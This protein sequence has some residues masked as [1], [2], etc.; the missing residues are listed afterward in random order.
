VIELVTL[1][2]RADRVWLVGLVR[3]IDRPELAPDL[4]SDT[5]ASQQLV[6]VFEVNLDA[7][8]SFVVVKD[9]LSQVLINHSD[10]FI[11]EQRPRLQVLVEVEQVQDVECPIVVYIEYLETESQLLGLV[12][13]SE[14]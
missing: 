14:R 1:H 7:I 5:R 9:V 13:T 8:E 11:C 2:R 10:D 12:V 3:L 4:I 6:K